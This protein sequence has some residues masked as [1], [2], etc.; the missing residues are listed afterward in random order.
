VAASFLGLEAAGAY[1][2]VQNI[3]LPMF[4]VLAAGTT[5]AMPFVAA[6]F[7]RQ[8]YAG[9]RSKSLRIGTALTLLALTYELA[10]ILGAGWI[11]PVLYGGKFA[12]YAWLVPLVGIVPLINATETAFSLVLRSLQRPAFYMID[13]TVTAVIGAS[14]ALLLIFYFAL[15]GAVVSLILIEV[16]ALFT[17]VIL[18]R[19]WFAWRLKSIDDSLPPTSK[20]SLP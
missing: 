20:H 1:R 13:K 17:Y 3:M 11:M 8:N 7:G 4:Q 6:D 2:A 15:P 16:A 12:A 18:Y 19:R 10:L 9:V 5:L 14:S